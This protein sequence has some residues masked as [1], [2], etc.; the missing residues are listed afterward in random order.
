[1]PNYC[2]P[3]FTAINDVNWWLPTNT[4][5]LVNATAAAV[6]AGRDPVNSLQTCVQACRDADCQFV[7]FDYSSSSCMMRVAP[8]ASGR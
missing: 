5:L 6:D 3:E 2:L 7:S 4:S 8:A 1:M